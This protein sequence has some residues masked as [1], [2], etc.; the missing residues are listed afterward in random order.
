MGAVDLAA[1][2]V[3]SREDGT[4]WQLKVAGTHLLIAGATGAGKSS[5]L[6]SL[7]QGVSRG[8]AVGDV[9]I[10]AVDPKGGMASAWSCPLHPV[11]GCLAR[12]D[13]PTPRGPRGGQG[14]PIEGLG[15]FRCA[16]P[17]AEAGVPTH[18]RGPGRA[19]DLDRLCGSLPNPTHRHRPRAAADSGQGLRDLRRRRCAGPRKDIVGWRDLFPTR[20]A[21]RLDN[22]FQVAM[23]LG[24]SARDDGA[25][26]DEISELT[27]GVAY[28]R[29]DATR[30]IMRARAGYSTTWPSPVWSTTSPDNGRTEPRATTLVSPF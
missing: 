17:P 9:Q 10:W 28:V 1:V 25:R 15:R 5:V 7:L 3:G 14:R 24:D 4:P 2:P 13:V 18:H 21:T 27:P 16:S 26:A 12:G 8:L 29:T 23:V 30:E 6:W 11:R 22:P 20:V 19:G